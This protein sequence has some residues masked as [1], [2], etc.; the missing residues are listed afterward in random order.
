MMSLPHSSSESAGFEHLHPE[1]Q[2]WIWRAGW[3]CL[4]D[5]Q[6]RAIPVLLKADRDVIVAAATA[7]G[8]TEAAFLPILSHLLAQDSP[9][10][11]IYISPLK[12]LINDQ[13]GRLSELCD[14]LELPVTPWHGD[15]SASRKHRYLKN[16]EGVLL[17][18]PESLEALFVNRGTSLPGL[19]ESLRYIVVDELHAFIGTERGKQLQSLMHRIELVAGRPIPRVGL[20]ATLGDMRL[21]S[22]FLNPGKSEKV[23]LI[24][25]GSGGQ[26]LKVRLK[27]YRI[28]PKVNN[29]KGA[30]A[31][32][33]DVNAD[34]ERNEDE[35][36]EIDVPQ[37]AIVQHLFKVMRGSNNLIF[38]NSRQK[39]E[40]YADRLRD[41]CERQGVPNEF[42]PHHGSLAKDLREDAE[43]ALKGGAPCATGVCTTTLELGIDIGNI[44]A[45]GQVGSPPSVASLRQRLGRSGRRAGEA[46][47]LWVHCI[48]KTLTDKSDL[49]DQL[50]Q[51]LVQTIAMIRLLIKGWFEPPRTHGLHASTLV[52]QSLSVIAQYGG[53][54]A[55]Q[56]WS[57]LVS[58]G[59]FSSVDKASFTTLLRAMGEKDLI[60]QEASGL[61]L[62]GELGERKINHY[63]FYAS[64]MS[65]E[66]FRLLRDGKPLGSLPVTRPLI[67]GQ[68][69]VFGGRRWKVLSVDTTDKV[70]VVSESPG[71]APPMFDG[72]GAT[73]HDHVRDEMRQVLADSAPCPFLDEAAAELLEEARSTFSMLG[74]HQTRI[75]ERG[76][77]AQLLT[78]KGD[79]TNDALCLM[80]NRVGV[81]TV[82]NGLAIEVAMPAAA[83]KPG[84]EQ[85]A[86]MNPK[87]VDEILEEVKNLEREKWDWVLPISL[88]R[89]SFAS[90][91]LDIAS[92]IETARFLLETEKSL[93]V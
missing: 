86:A 14:H 48:E 84:L 72:M 65:E 66:E 43:Q 57:A 90:T 56:L 19:F 9:G 10:S 38:P 64:F 2:R 12:A 34:D 16:P 91:H 69:I 11:V 50:R 39:V 53:V 15:V 80:L 79:Q 45:V 1:I 41:M 60:I 4:R 52:Q 8:K 42:W 73:V 3:T 25:S 13:W 81:P 49:S 87:A 7:A 63:D 78:W 77:R 28:P 36:L 70:I 58:Q 62:P 47:I 26:Q 22:T 82:P 83:L 93:G 67:V 88:L 37:L 44:R 27:G 71:G 92:A 6:E 55:A 20:S 17:I 24:E 30:S 51:D 54:T 40:W 74:L 46:A 85:V 33:A 61:L 23:T 89:R 35:Q 18:T 32:D 75:I 59:P 31:A 21:A 5:A 68:R 29:T 76:N